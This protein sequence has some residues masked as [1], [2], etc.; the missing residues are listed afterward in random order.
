MFLAGS[1]FLKQGMLQLF[2][3]RLQA[4]NLQHHTRPGVGTA[5]FSVVSNLSAIGLRSA[6]SKFCGLKKKS[7]SV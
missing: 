5:P 2:F 4:I 1:C 6:L 7:V 3:F